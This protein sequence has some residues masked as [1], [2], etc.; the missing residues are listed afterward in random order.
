MEEYFDIV[1]D[2]D[3]VVGRAT[4]KEVHAKGYV[5]R[6]VLFFIFDRDGPYLR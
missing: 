3:E 4:R 6:S 5:H 1:S 2:D